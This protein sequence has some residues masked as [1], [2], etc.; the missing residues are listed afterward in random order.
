MSSL[1]KIGVPQS[2][3]EN[4]LSAK[5][6]AAQKVASEIFPREIWSKIAF[7]V[8]DDVLA[9]SRM[10]SVSRE[11]YVLARD[12]TIWGKIAQEIGIQV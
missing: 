9:L 1:S 2:A 8:A 11:C 4:V 12:K 6:D 3:I 5:N 10:A 7:H